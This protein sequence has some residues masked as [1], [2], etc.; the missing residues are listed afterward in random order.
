MAKELI[1]TIEIPQYMQDVCISKKRRAKYNEEGEL[2]NK[3]TVGKPRMM[4]INGQSLWV[5]MNH[6]LRSKISKEIKHYLY[7]LIKDMEPIN[8]Y[9][10]GVDMEFYLPY[11]EY[12]IDNVCI[13]WHKCFHDC[14][15]AA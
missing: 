12:D 9:P 14:Q 15:K 13:W 4:R 8:E 2:T 10:I 1:R 7:E 5:T 3:R 11:G 6:N